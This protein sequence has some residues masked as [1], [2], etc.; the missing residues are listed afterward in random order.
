MDFLQII[1]ELREEK[2]R[3]DRV[4]ATLEDIVNRAESPDKAVP[5]S[6]RGR[7]GMSEDE[8]KQVSERMARY[9]ARRRAE[10][11]GSNGHMPKNAE[12]ASDTPEAG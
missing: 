7:K 12:A 6:R 1:R 5:K 2:K 11:A 9:W 3:L 8:R 10:T 4:I